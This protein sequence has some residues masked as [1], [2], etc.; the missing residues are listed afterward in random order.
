[1]TTPA[2]NRKFGR[3]EFPAPLTGETTLASTDPAA[4]LMLEVF[5]AAANSDLALRWQD[6]SVGTPVSGTDPV[7]SKHPQEP[8]ADYMREVKVGFPALFVYRTGDPTFNETGLWKVQ[9]TQRWGVDYI[10]GPLDAGNRRKLKA[11]LVAMAK[12]ISQVVARGGHNAYGMDSNNVQP[13]QVFGSATAD[14]IE[15]CG[16]TSI[17]TIGAEL[18]PAK[19][20]ADGPIYHALTVTLESV[21]QDGWVDETLGTTPVIV[22]WGYGLATPD[23]ETIEDFVEESSDVEEEGD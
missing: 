17:R 7:A 9:M 10:I 20:S 21:E 6:A 13:L 5:A 16:F 4:D 1:M 15:V 3:L 11:M 2:F 18:I 19:F 12:L 22:D 23:E 8:D 14:G